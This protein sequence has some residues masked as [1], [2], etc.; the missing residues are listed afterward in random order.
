[1]DRS[2][3][4]STPALR[5]ER[6]GQGDGEGPSSEPPTAPRPTQEERPR[7]ILLVEDEPTLRSMYRKVLDRAGFSVEVA[8]DPADACA[9]VESGAITPDLLI[10]DVGLANLSGP[11]LA[12]RLREILPD[13]PV[14]LVSGSPPDKDL[15]G[16]PGGPQTRFLAKPFRLPQLLERVHEMLGRP[17]LSVSHR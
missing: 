17:D 14:L 12:A 4:G 16:G 10:S 15:V 11:N 3:E 7:T 2:S 5:E 1:M 8:D 6:P 9:R 13:L